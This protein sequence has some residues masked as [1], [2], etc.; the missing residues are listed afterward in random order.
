MTAE[1]NRM[2]GG[3]AYRLNF[4]TSSSTSSSTAAPAPAPAPA[5]IAT[6]YSSVVKTTTTA[7]K[8]ALC[9]GVRTRTG[10]GKDA[11]SVATTTPRKSKK[12]PLYDYTADFTKMREPLLPTTELPLVLNVSTE[13][14]IGDAGGRREGKTNGDSDENRNTG[15]ESNVRCIT[16]LFLSK[17]RLNR[18]QLNRMNNLLMKKQKQ[19]EKLAA[20]AA[21]FSTLDESVIELSAGSILYNQ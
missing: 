21:I 2:S 1:G 16:D 5:P 19:T 6:S 12:L 9:T 3:K 8:N 7:T 13:G 14:A 18:Y 17:K 20:A 11:G 4:K 10:I 15:S